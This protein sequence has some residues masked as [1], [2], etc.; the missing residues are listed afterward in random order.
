MEFKAGSGASVVISPAPFLNAMRLKAAIFKELA[1]DGFELDMSKFKDDAKIEDMDIDVA[2]ILKVAMKV[3][4]SPHVFAAILLCLEKC[5]YGG[6]K[7]TSDTFEP[8]AAREDYYEIVF[9]CMKVN[10]SPFFKGL[11]SKLSG[12]NQ[13]TQFITQKR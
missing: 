6:V 11:L 4:S 13:L 2:K 8:D 5:S 10:L 3:D 1:T 9:A 7:I 12:I